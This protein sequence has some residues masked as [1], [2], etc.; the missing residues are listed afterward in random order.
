M[1]EQL[2]MLRRHPGLQAALLSPGPSPT[3][4]EV[5]RRYS[6]INRDILQARLLS[7]SGREQL[8]INRTPAGLRVVPADQLQNKAERDYFREGFQAPLNSLYLSALDLNREHG[9]VER[10]LQPTIRLATAIPAPSDSRKL[11]MLVINLNGDSLLNQLPADARRLGLGLVETMVVNEDGFYLQHGQTGRRWGFEPLAP[12]GT[13]GGCALNLRCSNPSLWARLGSLASGS[14]T[15]ASGQWSWQRLDSRMVLAPQRTASG[16]PLRVNPRRWWLITHVPAPAL[17]RHLETQ[18]APFRA[19]GGIALAL[20]G[21]LS[22]LA[23]L[24]RRREVGLIASL[25]QA[26]ANYALL[27][28]NAADVVLTLERGRIRWISASVQRY[29]DIAARC[30]P[31][32]PSCSRTRR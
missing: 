5:L 8:R 25:H 26:N 31:L 10:P 32:W 2:L 22:L 21:S 28:E 27:A 1:A 18:L 3:A 15:D 7:A 16:Q 14:V 30:S 20:L 17:E 6:Q 19:T 23:A 4:V 11:G 12:Q 24:L 9:S 29:T 13:A